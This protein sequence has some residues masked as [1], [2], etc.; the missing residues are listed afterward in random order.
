MCPADDAT[1]L[2]QLWLLMQPFAALSF[3]LP[4]LA[5]E[6]PLQDSER[7]CAF[8]IDSALQKLPE[9]GESIL[10][11][12]YLRG[13]GPSNADFD[14][15]YFLVRTSSSK[16]VIARLSIITGRDSCLASRM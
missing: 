10:G 14:F 13:F 5:G 12:F 2:S 15:F 4:E 8:V 7:L 6:W 16:S 11:V 9:G 3:S 1:G